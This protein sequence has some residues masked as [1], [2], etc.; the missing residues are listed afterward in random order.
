MR[1]LWS[2]GLTLWGKYEK[3]RYLV[4]GGL[5]TVLNYAVYAACLWLFPGKYDYIIATA[6]SFVAAVIFAYYA[7]KN[8][9]FH[10]KTESKEDALR[11]AGSFLV[12]RLISFGF[13]LAAMWLLVDVLRVNKWVAKLPVN[14]IIV[15]LNYVFSKLFIFRKPEVDAR[16]NGEE[17]TTV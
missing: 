8:M 16:G 5:T 14:V 9:V 7:N 11:E 17:N 13:E 10:A 12:M 6:V 1:A 3:L 2:W 4:V 15:V